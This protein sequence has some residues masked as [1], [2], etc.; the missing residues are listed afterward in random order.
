MATRAVLGRE[1][2]SLADLRDLPLLSSNCKH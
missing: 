2:L 1:D